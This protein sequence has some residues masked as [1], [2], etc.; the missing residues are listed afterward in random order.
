[1]LIERHLDPLAG[2]ADTDTHIHLALVKSIAQ[3]VGKVG[4]VAAV[5]PAVRPIVDQFH[6]GG[7]L[8]EEVPHRYLDIISG[9]VT[10][11]PYLMYSCYHS[12]LL[13]Q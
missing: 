10:G 13:S 4:I 12:L 6:L 1:M 9:V 11:Q 5:R 3:H 2:A 8:C 7:P